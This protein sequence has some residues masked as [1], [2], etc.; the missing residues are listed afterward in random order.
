MPGSGN[1]N[2]MEALGATAQPGI[3]ALGEGQK[4]VVRTLTCTKTQGHT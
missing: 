4:A 1:C 3:L 2:K